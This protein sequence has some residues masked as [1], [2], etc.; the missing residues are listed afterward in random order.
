VD[1]PDR[2]AARHQGMWRRW[3]TRPPGGV[4]ECDLLVIRSE[5]VTSWPASRRRPP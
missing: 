4:P 3:L 2:R 5:P 1:E